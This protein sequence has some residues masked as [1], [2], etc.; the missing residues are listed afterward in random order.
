MSLG[1]NLAWMPPGHLRPPDDHH[2]DARGVNGLSRVSSGTRTPQMRFSVSEQGSQAGNMIADADAAAEEDARITLF[3]DLYNLS[4]AKINALFSAK[5]SESAPSEAVATVPEAPEITPARPQDS[6]QP[7]KKAARKLDDDNYDEYDDEEESETQENANASPLK[8]RS[9]VTPL[10]DASPAQRPSPATATP[11]DSGK[12]TKKDTLEET[13]KK[14]EE[15][16]KATEQAARQSFQTMFHTLENDHDA[17][18]EQERL[19]ES[20]RLVEA[21]MSG[22]GVNNSG[23]NGSSGANGYGSLSNANLG[24]SS[25]TLK[26]LIARI[27]MKR[28]M[29]QASDAEL[30]SLMSEVRKNRS[31]WASEE[32]VGQEE[33]Y[34]AAEKVLSELKAMTE[35]SSF[36][37]SRVNKREAPDYH[38]VIKHPMDLGTMTKKL[39]TLQYKSK[40]EFVDDLNL[41]WANCL[42]YNASPEHFLR[43]HALFMRKETEKLVPLIPDIVIRDRA[44]VEAEER[45]LQLAEM[46]GAEESDDEPIMSSR[47]RKAPGKKTSQKGAAAPSRQ[48]PSG[49]EAPSG[50]LGSQPKNSVGPDA[51]GLAEGSQ[52][53]LSTPPPGTLTPLGANG[54]GAAASGSQLDAMEMDSFVAPALT[55]AGTSAIGFDYDDPEY[56]IWK[57]VT[58]KDRALIAAERHRLF[59]GDKLNAEERALLRTKTGMRRWLKN[60]KQAGPESDKAVES[61]SNA[62]QPETSE[63][64]AE[65]IEEEDDRVIPDYYDVM[66]GIPDIPPHLVWREDA[67]GNVVDNM[68]EFLHIL[69]KGSFTQ[70]DSKLSRRMDANMRQM[71]E[72][73]KICSKVSIVKQMQLQSQVYQNQFQKYNPEPFVEQDVS[74]HVMNDE[75][76][77]INPWISK[78]A[79]Q[80]SVGKLLYHTGFEEYQPS[81]LDAITDIASEFFVKISRTLKEYMEAPKIPVTETSDV[82]NSSAAKYKSPYTQQEVILHT[83]SAVGT[84]VESLES[85][86]KDD[87]ERVGTK[88]G[89]IH[90]RLRAHFTE[91]LRPAF[92]DTTGDGSNAFN[93][94]S[95]QFVGGDF[96]EDIDEDFFG[97]KEMGLDR[98]F[99]LASLSV[100][101]HLLQNRMYN[102]HQSQ[103][104]SASQTASTLFPVPPPYPHIT[105]ESLP[106][107]IGLVQNFFL[108]KL[109]AN[110]EEPLTEDLELPLKQ[111]PS[112]PKLPGSGKIVP[113]SNSNLTTS[114]QK[115]PLPPSIAQMSSSKT[116]LSFAEPSKKKAKKNNGTSADTSTSTTMGPSGN[117]ESFASLIG[118]SKLSTENKPGDQAASN[119]LPGEHLK[120]DLGASNDGVGMT[121]SSATLTGEVDPHHDKLNGINSSNNENAAGTTS[122]MSPESINGHS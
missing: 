18:K 13:R 6:G 73:R 17:M 12:D 58:K 99:G 52:N 95:E 25:L 41:I 35:H 89:V 105:M 54:I 74:T 46:D 94:G 81:A 37:L 26:N 106:S 9:A 20:E 32:K 120:G 87:I 86:I 90:E 39:K 117:D 96:A 122:M 29:V 34:E 88:L 79:L 14:L 91:L 42:K 11:A 5:R 119:K 82:S 19:E 2:S 101:F 43:K 16:K 45:R 80:R 57:Q 97:F 53:G 59:K 93:D 38:T 51:D 85:Y 102:A 118:D 107:Q 56:Q 68:E 71:Q 3:R 21:E 63:T 62:L 111:R 98:E 60:Q 50:P 47:G 36:F 64:L 84:D 83:L 109:Q 108:Q 75:G 10:Y 61:Q 76:P 44:E 28:T 15:G 77:V 4:E 103:N 66:S 70:P 33:L 27:D 104:T 112:R 1:Q 22:Q 69:P 65:G 8:A 114:P 24:A 48:T 30:R 49:S 100:P 40:Q 115:R 110:G 113:P 121:G 55:M 78:A 23:N 31:K 92:H 72:T 67:E 116:G 7:A